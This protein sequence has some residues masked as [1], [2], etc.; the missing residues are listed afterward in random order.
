MEGS[1]LAL[2]V[3]PL[4]TATKRHGAISTACDVSLPDFHKPFLTRKEYPPLHNHALSMSLL[5]G[6]IDIC[7]Q[8]RQRQSTGRVKFQQKSLMNSVRTH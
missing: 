3:L 6:S 8:L 5:F 4:L 2:S 7:E 1:S